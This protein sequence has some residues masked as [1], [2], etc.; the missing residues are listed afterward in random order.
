MRVLFTTR[1]SAGHL[2]PLVPF[3]NA[4]RHAGHDVLV[5]AQ[6][7][8]RAHV[9]RAG[10]PYAP[11]GDPP[12]Q[13]WGPL[14]EQI[15]RMPFEDANARMIGEFFADI[16]SRAA[17]P[18]L[19]AA[20]AE[21]GPDVIVRESWEYASTL[22]AD[23]HAIPIVRIGLGLAAVEQQSVELAAPAVDALRRANGLPADP[24]G[25]RLRDTPYL[26]MMPAPLDEGA[27]AAPALTHRFAIEV[28]VTAAPPPLDAWFHGAGDPLVLVSFGSVA[29]GEHLPFYPHLYRAAIDALAPLPVRVLVTIGAARDLTALGP[30]P[31]NVHVEEWVAQDAVLPQTAAAVIHGG[32][33]STLGALRHGVPLA[34]LP[35][36][37]SDQFANARAVERAGAGIAVGANDDGRPVLAPPRPELVAQLGPAVEALLG[38]PS[39]ARVARDIAAAAAALPAVDAAVDVIATAYA[40]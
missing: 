11:V 1:G 10:L 16:D 34:V 8:H 20:V 26:T 2:L 7:Q 6:A 27:A 30:L 29:A 40:T 22:V 19:R 4:C 13:E 38:E 28:A 24:T 25:R 12:P 23:L 36:F 35:L 3:A 31:A 14:M 21:F 32:Y 33:G 39:Y 18:A 5:A 17:L 15:V 37:S 9:E